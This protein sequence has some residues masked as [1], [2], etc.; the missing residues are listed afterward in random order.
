MRIGFVCAWRTGA[1]AALAR[2]VVAIFRAA[3]HDCFPFEWDERTQAPD[4][5]DTGPAPD[6]SSE[7]ATW[8]MTNGLRAVFL[9]DDARFADVA[10]MR[11]SG[12]VTVG[13][14]PWEHFGDEHV[15][16]ALGAYDCLYAT[17]AA[18]AA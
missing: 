12:V 17:H 15:G 3:G 1:R 14:F 5:T 11:A 18:E 13:A 10:A 9:F 2:A 6:E 4:D 7:Y 16:R 8:A